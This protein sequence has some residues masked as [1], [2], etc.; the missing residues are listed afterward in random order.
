MDNNQCHIIPASFCVKSELTR[1]QSESKF[2]EIYKNKTVNQNN[3]NSKAIHNLL[4]YK[5]P[6]I[7][8]SYEF[9]TLHAILCPEIASLTSTGPRL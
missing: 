6:T 7:F 1:K 9:A 2:F 5:S 4:Q 3:N 8:I